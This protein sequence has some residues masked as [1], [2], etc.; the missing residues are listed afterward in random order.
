MRGK[1]IGGK[2]MAVF[3]VLLALFMAAGVAEEE[4]TDDGGQWKYV[5]E[6]FGAVITG[7]VE[8]PSDDLAIPEEL[9]GHP[10]TGIGDN[11]FYENERIMSVII[12]TSMKRIG[13]A[14]FY[15]CRSLEMV[16]LSDAFGKSANPHSNHAQ[17]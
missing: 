3:A 9:D 16:I 5:L 4:R 7:Y 17:A 12:P 1:Q 11:A 2:T 13:E 6:E 10:V 8:E 15:D 14:A